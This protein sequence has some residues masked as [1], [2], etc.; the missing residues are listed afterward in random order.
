MTICIGLGILGVVVEFTNLGRLH[1]SHEQT[2][3]A[4]IDIPH[5]YEGNT[6]DQLRQIMMIKDELLRNSK[7]LWASITLC[8][9]ITR[10]LR[11]LFYKI[12]IQSDRIK[13]RNPFY[14]MMFIGLN[15]YILFLVT[16]EALISIPA[17]YQ[18]TTYYLSTIY[19]TIN[20]GGQLFGLNMLFLCGGYILTIN[21]LEY[22]TF[23]Q[24]AK[25]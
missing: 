23:K 12:K 15:W 11:H 10:N 18:Q 7:N 4:N 21:F 17:N 9:S 6:A 24:V 1:L 25:K 20:H 2:N 3:Y 5:I 16:R 22:S 13:H 14:C 19:F 8:F